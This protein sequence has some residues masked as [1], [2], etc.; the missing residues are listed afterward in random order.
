MSDTDDASPPRDSIWFVQSYNEDQA[1]AQ[2]DA[3]DRDHTSSDSDPRPVSRPAPRV[4][5]RPRRRASASEIENALTNT[6]I[7][8]P[9]MGSSRGLPPSRARN[10]AL[11]RRREE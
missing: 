4:Q 5:D 6:S 11:Q 9:E 1:A 2:I 3:Q 8:D 10:L 7:A